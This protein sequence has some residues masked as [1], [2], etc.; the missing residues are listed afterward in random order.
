LIDGFK[1]ISPTQKVFGS[2]LNDIF[3]ICGKL[4]FLKKRDRIL[5]AD[6]DLPVEEFLYP[7]AKICRIEARSEGNVLYHFLEPYDFQGTPT[8]EWLDNFLCEREEGLSKWVSN[9]W[10]H[11]SPETYLKLFKEWMFLKIVRRTFD[12]N[13]F[14]REDELANLEKVYGLCQD[15][16][17]F[18]EC[19]TNLISK[20]W[21]FELIVELGKKSEEYAAATNCLLEE[22]EL[23]LK[24][25]PIM[26]D[27]SNSLGKLG[28][29]MGFPV[30]ASIGEIV[31]LRS[32]DETEISNGFIDT[33]SGKFATIA[34]TL[35]QKGYRVRYQW[36]F[37]SKI[38]KYPVE[39]CLSFK[40]GSFK[41]DGLPDYFR[42]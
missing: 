3:R 20:I 28:A 15:E 5:R 27:V 16:F 1:L 40:S 41:G 18:W 29:N 39:I 34:E 7:S 23:V 30:Y 35:A 33:K 11:K 4:S 37:G 26:N 24:V 8:I 12:F 2:I 42:N 25:D 19:I 14:L 17:R 36:P 31:L 9:N 10:H 13:V 38:D 6:F 21:F 22:K 32:F